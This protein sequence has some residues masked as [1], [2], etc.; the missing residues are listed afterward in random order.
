MFTSAL[1][2]FTNH[3]PALRDGDE[4]AIHQARVAIR[5][6]REA[7]TLIRDAFDHDQLTD[8]EARL[9][10]TFKALGRARDADTAQR[11]V[12]HVALRFPLAPATLNVLQASLART[13]LRARQKLMKTL[14]KADIGGL[15]KQMAHGSRA[16]S[17]FWWGG[18][19]WRTV[20]RTHLTDRALGMRHAMDRAGGIYFPNRSH[21]AR[22]ALK[23]FRYALEMAE[24]L[25]EW[26]GTRALRAL[27]KAQDALGD[28]HDREM[29]LS[30][31]RRLGDAGAPV[32]AVEVAA[33]E[34]FFAGEIRGLHEKYLAVRT[35]ILEACD[36]AVRRPR[37][38][39][40]RASAMAAAALT[41][42][43]WIA[44]QRRRA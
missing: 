10:R 19:A 1:E 21:N 28:A 15:P 24:G 30:R 5:R 20:L 29:L 7:A 41:L 23:E 16:G 39:P 25:G 35:Q 34:H 3:T 44:R 11:L 40:L 13:Q 31:L 14:E 22:I 18:R 17:R 36:L 27:R 9:R 4:Q 32:V 6:L 33:L 2:D 42:P 38:L 37:A 12:Q 8:L 26:Q 43:V